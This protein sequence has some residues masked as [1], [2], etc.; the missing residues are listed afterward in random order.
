MVVEVSMQAP[1]CAATFAVSCGLAP[2]QHVR[3]VTKREGQWDYEG[4]SVLKCDE[5]MGA[6][7]PCVFHL[8]TIILTHR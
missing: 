2:T 5:A 6:D 3:L 4:G 1:T 8:S 7:L